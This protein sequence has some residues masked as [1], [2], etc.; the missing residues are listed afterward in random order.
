MPLLCVPE[1]TASTNTLEIPLTVPSEP[2]QVT[3]MFGNPE[4]SEVVQ[5]TATGDIV[6]S[7]NGAVEQPSEV[8]NDAEKLPALP[9]TEKNQQKAVEEPKTTVK[10]KVTSSASRSKSL[11]SAFTNGGNR[12]TLRSVNWLC[13]PQLFTDTVFKSYMQDLDNVLKLN[14]RKN[15]LD[16]TE[17]PQNNAVTVK[18]AIDKVGDLSKVLISESSGSKQIDDIVLQ[19][20]KE[21]FEGEKSQDLNNS[22]LK[23]DMYYLKVVIKL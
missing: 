6:A 3:D 4:E 23:Q 13:A 22:A 14:L 21:S 2:E 7:D 18:M 11:A 12:A 8:K 1:N 16:A 19:S 9:K 5:E 17:T 15:I 20:I 10:E